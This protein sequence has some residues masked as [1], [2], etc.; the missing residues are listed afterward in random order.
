MLRLLV[1]S[2]FLALI[3]ALPVTGRAASQPTASFDWSMPD[4]FGLDQNHDGVID[5][6]PETSDR[7][8]L[9]EQIDP[10]TF[11][12]I[13][14]ACASSSDR[15]IVSYSWVV[16]PAP[17]VN[18]AACK[19]SRQLAEGSYS[20]TLTITDDAGATDVLK[21]NV[22]VQ[23]W[24]IVALGDS[25]GSGEGSPDIP[26]PPPQLQEV[27]SAQQAVDDAQADYDDAVSQLATVQ[28]NFDNTLAAARAIAAPCG[29]SDADHN[30]TYETF[31]LL[32]VDLVGCTQAVIQLGI[33]AV[34]DFWNLVGEAVNDTIHV[35][36]A[37]LDLATAHVNDA[38]ATLGDFADQ[39]ANLQNTLHATW[40]DRRCHRSAR[41]GIA[42]AALAIEHADPH[43]SVTFVHLACSGA[44]AKVGFLEP[45]QGVDVELNN[46]PLDCDGHPTQCVAPQIE[47]AAQ[48]VG[49]REVDAVFMSIGGNDANFAPI[50]QSCI[51]LE[52][53][54]VAPA[55]PDPLVV[56]GITGICAPLRL[57]GMGPLCE[58]YLQSLVIQYGAGGETADQ[59]L[60]EGLAELAPQSDR[61][62]LYQ[63]VADRFKALMPK[64]T[65]DR[66]YISEYPNATQND[67]LSHCPDVFPQNNLPGLSLSETVFADNIVTHGLDD[68]VALN[69]ADEGWNFIGGV[70]DA[71]AGHGYCADDHWIT[72]FDETFLNQGNHTG[73]VHPNPSGQAAYRDLI[74]PAIQNDL[75]PGGDLNTPRL[76]AQP[77]VADGGGL[78]TTPEGSTITLDGSGS[79][80][81]DGNPLTYQWSPTT[82]SDGSTLSGETTSAPTVHA[83][84]DGLLAI[85]LTVSN[86]SG[87]DSDLAKVKVV[88]VAP[89]VSAGGDAG[90]SEGA[91]FSRTGSFTDPGAAD[92]HTATVDYGDGTGVAPLAVT[93]ARTFSLS[94]V[95]ADDG[96]YNV[97]VCVTD[98]DGGTGCDTAKV[99]VGNV[100]P[101]VT[102]PSDFSTLEGATVT[103]GKAAVNDAGT[104]DTHTATVSWGDGTPVEPA[105]VSESPFGPPGS[106]FG[107]NSALI[108][109]H[110]YAD[111]GAYTIDI[112]VTDDDGGTDCDSSV[113]TVGNAAP[114][115][116]AGPDASVDEG[117]TFSLAPATFVDPGTLDTHTA[118]VDWGDG[119]T[120]EAA[121]VS[122]APSGP[123]GSTSG[124]NGAISATHVYADDGAYTV[125]VC[126]TDD[127]AGLGCDALVANVLNVAPAL[128][129]DQVASGASFVLPLVPIGVA[130]HF[131]DPGSL[132]THTATVDWGDG[133]PPE[134]VGTVT[135]PFSADHAYATAGLYTIAVTVTDDDGGSATETHDIEVLDAVEAIDRSVTSLTDLATDPATSGLARLLLLP[136]IDALYGN[137]GG[138]SHNGAISKLGAGQTNAALEK[139]QQAEGYLSL[140]ELFDPN[141]DLGQIQL[142]LAWVAKSVATDAVM[143]AD[144]AAVSRGDRVRVTLANALIDAGDALSAGGQYPAAVSLYQLALR[145]VD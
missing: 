117:S 4:R 122:E 112:C 99:K 37:A 58:V 29:W 108:G 44:E 8:G 36:Q 139:I 5:Y 134:H 78:Y 40:E 31:D 100:A 133:A 94:H 60:Q 123:P 82:F 52:P 13:L 92:T 11:T 53:C 65:S 83:V 121:T 103:L 77:P 119:S 91:A 104:A 57:F 135:S 70:Y 87:S 128:Q 27:A 64:L 21:K 6:F 2:V 26:I 61:S 49:N 136:A 74:R 143:Q 18:T 54:N 79:Y 124:A 63:Q 84:D 59:F 15:P 102:A 138:S 45:Y 125:S 130:A 72:R 24:L 118:T 47:R 113:V 96:T 12:V 32:S 106:T 39:L 66:M 25:Y 97:D 30:G 86:T 98:D 68:M 101:V 41:A 20:V 10:G 62:G 85:T 14:D 48:L 129:I 132:D 110:A 81:P 76:P 145:T 46:P 127:D 89:S 22:V 67:D 51:V 109:A 131:T 144:A 115:V 34:G 90:I 126:A 69:A 55:R 7:P 1:I 56:G 140:A 16:A 88:N 3:C 114:V 75:Y 80:A 43:T 137:H 142:T 71:Y 38:F 23:D 35:A 42:Q 95:Y 33:D 116:D 120:V 105:G 93:A 50:V 111:N 17:A 28:T 73:V 107:A 141:I 19:L 9:T